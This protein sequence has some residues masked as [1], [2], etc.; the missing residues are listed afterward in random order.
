MIAQ[1]K[2]NLKLLQFN[3]LSVYENIIHFS[4][5]RIGGVSSNI[6]ESLNLGYTVN[7]NPKSVTQNLDSLARSLGFEKDKMVSPKQTHSKNIGIVNSTKDIFP[8]TDALIT[9]KPGVCIFIRTADCVPILL[10]D[11][12]NKALAAIHSGWKSTIQ[13]ISK[14]TIEL[15]QKEFGTEPK[16]LIAGIGPSIGPKVYEV[17]AEVADLFQK[18]FG[19]DHIVIPKKNSNKYLLNLWKV[20]KQILIE[21]GMQESQI[22]IAEICTYA[23]S[24]LFYSARR[25][26]VKTGRHATG[27]MLRL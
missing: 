3:N 21:S 16:N 2:N 11:P 4:S 25:D 14:H 24:E 15:M 8:D 17:G 7:D 27:I 20:N 13:K 19:M 26:G 10:Y 5:T 9:N 18:Q 23:N 6:L 12:I 22:E 1:V